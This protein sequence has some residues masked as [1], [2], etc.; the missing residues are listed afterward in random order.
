MRLINTKA[1]GIYDYL[2]GFLLMTSPWIFGFENLD[3]PLLTILACGGSMW[4]TALFSNYEL[5]ITKKIPLKMHLYADLLLGS[6]LALSPWLL[7]FHYLVYKPHLIFGLGI[8]GVSI[9]TDRMLS[10]EVLQAVNV[11][12]KSKKEVKPGVHPKEISFERIINESI[13]KKIPL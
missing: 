6:L 7:E 3:I 9:C 13:N 8:I 12:K 5:G 1:H 4:V 11:L 2:M 10:Y